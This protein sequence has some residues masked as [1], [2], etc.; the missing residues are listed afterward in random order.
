MD[1]ERNETEDKKG[2]RNGT[3][4]ALDIPLSCLSSAWL[5]WAESRNKGRPRRRRRRRRR[6]RGVA[7]IRRAFP[8]SLHLEKRFN[9]KILRNHR[10]TLASCS[11]TRYICCALLSAHPFSPPF[12]LRPS[13]HLCPFTDGEHTA[14]PSVLVHSPLTKTKAGKRERKGE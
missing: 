6:R 5:G 2:A 3:K 8:A 12:T 7:F 1:G 10:A 13:F 11:P 4:I 14:G 9:Y